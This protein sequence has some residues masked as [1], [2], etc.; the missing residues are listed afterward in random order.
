[1]KNRPSKDSRDE[2]IMSEPA[3]RPWDWIWVSASASGGGHI[4]L[5]DRDGRKIAA[6]WGKA[7]EKTATADLIIKAVN[8]EGQKK[9]RLGGGKTGRPPIGKRAMTAAE[10]QRR[11]RLGLTTPRGARSSTAGAAS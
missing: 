2:K 10:R 8:A 7:E 5:V 6:I 3:P 4:Y 11:H 9:S 1:M